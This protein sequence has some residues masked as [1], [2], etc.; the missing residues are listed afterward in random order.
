MVRRSALRRGSMKR[1]M[2]RLWILFAVL[3]FF[4]IPEG[5][6]EA[7]EL[8]KA[9]A[10]VQASVIAFLKALRTGNP[11]FLLHS[12]GKPMKKFRDALS[13]DP[14]Y[15]R[16]IRSR[17]ENAVL[18]VEQIVFQ[19]KTEGVVDISIEYPEGSLEVIAYSIVRTGSGTWALNS[20]IQKP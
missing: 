15:A 5:R 11:D 14:Q 13:A 2:I 18:K 3:T 19:T 8:P 16:M 12:A 7:L 17:Y 10:E 4:W 9:E 20:E 6:P 1:Y